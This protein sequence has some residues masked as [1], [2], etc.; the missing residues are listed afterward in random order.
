MGLVVLQHVGCSW[1]RGQ[2]H[3]PCIGRQI[4]NHWSTRKIPMFGQLNE[5]ILGEVLLSMRRQ[6]VKGAN[7]YINDIYTAHFPLYGGQHLMS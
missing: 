3:V 6:S 7:N 4:L 5:W 2:T 1:S